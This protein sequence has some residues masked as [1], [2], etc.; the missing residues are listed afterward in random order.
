LN[1]ATATSTTAL[2]TF[3]QRVVRKELV[4]LSLREAPKEVPKPAVA[5]KAEVDTDE[6]W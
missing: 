3:P 5:K 6:A 4:K 1:S 2:W